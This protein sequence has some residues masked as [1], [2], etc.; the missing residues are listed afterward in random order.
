MVGIGALG[1]HPA[2]LFLYPDFPKDSHNCLAPQNEIARVHA[3]LLLALVDDL[4]QLH[5]DAT[6]TFLD[7]YGA[8]VY[9]LDHAQELVLLQVLSS[10]A[11]SDPTPIL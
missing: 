5:S 4:G 1:C 3:Q 7:L 2:Y 8:N 11:F 9:V 10:I 6:Y